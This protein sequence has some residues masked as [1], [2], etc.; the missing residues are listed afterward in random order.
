M[1]GAQYGVLVGPD[2]I[3]D[4][5]EHVERVLVTRMVQ[6]PVP[7]RLR[8]NQA[9]ASARL[10]LAEDR[11]PPVDTERL[12]RDTHVGIAPNSSGLR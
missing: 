4:L 5:G 10:D 9:T 6:R 12:S 1:Q 7:G 3:A 11:R 2:R 8:L